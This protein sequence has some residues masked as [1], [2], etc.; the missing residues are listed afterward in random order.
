MLPPARSRVHQAWGL[1]LPEASG[2]GSEAP[3]PPPTYPL[4]TSQH[5]PGSDLRFPSYTAITFLWAW[6]TLSDWL[7][8]RGDLIRH[9]GPSLLQTGGLEFSRS[10]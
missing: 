8:F 1:H 10:L 5:T 7:S 6:K 2:R 4:K 3:S 9:K